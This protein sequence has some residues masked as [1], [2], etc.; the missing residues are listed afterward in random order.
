MHI[1]W[2][3]M[4]LFLAVAEA[5]SV[6][7]AARLLHITQPTASRRL[8]Q[9]ES[10]LGER[11]FVRSVEGVA[12]TP[13]GERMIEPLRRMA[14][15]AGEVDRAGARTETAPSGIVRVT[16]APGVAFELLAPF[17]AW[18]RGKLPDVRLEVVS[19]VSYVDLVRREA[20]LALRLGPPTRSKEL[21]TLA[22]L[23]HTVA[24]FGSPA[25][26][27]TLP[28]KPRLADVAWIGWA[29]P[30]EHLPPNPELTQM[31]PGFRPVF[32]SDDFLVQLRAAQAGI[33]A[34]FLGRAR[35][36]F[37]EDSLVELDVDVGELRRSIHLVCAKTALDI[38]RVRAVA[39]LLV[40]ELER[41]R[42]PT[43]ARAKRAI[44]G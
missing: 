42:E 12:P 25:Y 41:A 18:L 43:R 24:A 23:E 34:I 2:D 10:T 19:S 31:I 27:K 1:P 32:A 20:D 4:Q 15:W 28:K 9:L 35:H 26:A 37:S 17:A 6:T 36:R 44:S 16:A 3:A 5:R 40:A 38:P 33:G 22:S 39:D 8:S 21:V 29:P 13:F 7:A 11:L 14:E 30:L